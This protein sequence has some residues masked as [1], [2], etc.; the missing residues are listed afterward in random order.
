MCMRLVK[1][2]VFIYSTSALNSVTK[3][4]LLHWLSAFQILDV[5]P[6]KPACTSGIYL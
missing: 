5:I 2:L 4:T 6:I 1:A 3:S